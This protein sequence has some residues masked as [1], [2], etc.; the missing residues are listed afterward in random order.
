MGRRNSDE[1]GG[2]PM[3]GIVVATVVATLVVFSAGP[4]LAFQCPSLIKKIEDETATRFDPAAG[5]A[6]EKAAKAAELHG[7]GKHAESVEAAK[8]GLKA[9]GM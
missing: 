9:L 7:Q 3:R 1:R 8:E 4:A 2:E 5:E 6:K